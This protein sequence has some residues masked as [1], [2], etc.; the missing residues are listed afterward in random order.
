MSLLVD[1]SRCYCRWSFSLH[2]ILKHVKAR[3]H[4]IFLYRKRILSKIYL[5]IF[6]F[7]WFQNVLS[8][9]YPFQFS[10]NER[11]RLLSHSVTSLVLLP[12]R[13]HYYFFLI[14]KWELSKSFS[15]SKVKKI[16]NYE[17]HFYITSVLRITVV[18]CYFTKNIYN[19][20]KF[21]HELFMKI[22]CLM[23]HGI[24]YLKK[25]Y[26]KTRLSY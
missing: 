21:Y 8:V 18:L 25:I 11:G 1:W 10:A 9:K 20:T 19:L 16:K 17:F 7:S 23:N 24:L 13:K 14:K 3:F 6:V 2:Q 22:N 26:L 4:S 12:L 5:E 15:W